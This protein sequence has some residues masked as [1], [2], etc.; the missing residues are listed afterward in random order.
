MV[1]NDAFYLCHTKTFL[2]HL[3][4]N[5]LMDHA[6]VHA[7]YTEPHDTLLDSMMTSQALKDKMAKALILNVCIL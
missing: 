1:L 7:N 6:H 4:T 5:N 3:G 2:H